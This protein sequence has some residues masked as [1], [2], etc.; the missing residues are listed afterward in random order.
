VAVVRHCDDYRHGLPVHKQ[1]KLA[2]SVLN[3]LYSHLLRELPGGAVSI[4]SADKSNLLVNGVLTGPVDA[5]DSESRSR[6]HRRMEKI[7][8]KAA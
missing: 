4:E 2:F 1:I 6:W 5:S 8:K 3:R 7:D